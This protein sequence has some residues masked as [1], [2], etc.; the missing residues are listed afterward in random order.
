MVGTITPLNVREIGRVSLLPG[1]SLYE[2]VR[3]NTCPGV[4]LARAWS[5]VRKALVDRAFALGH[6]NL[7]HSMSRQSQG[8]DEWRTKCDVCGYSDI[9]RLSSETANH[10]YF[11]VLSGLDLRCEGEGGRAKEG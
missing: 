7:R 5:D 6:D 10:V 4:Q 11:Q 1:W 2:V 8:I 9:V 3:C